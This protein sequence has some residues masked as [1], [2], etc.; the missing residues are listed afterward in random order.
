[1]KDRSPLPIAV[2]RPSRGRVLHLAPH[3]DDDVIACG[4]TL[5]HHA[6]AGDPVRVVVV[7]SG[8]AGDPEGRYDSASYAELRQSEA[9][10]GGEHLGLH[11]YEF[12]NFPEGHEPSAEELVGATHKLA[13][14]I[15]EFAPDI[16]YSPWI[17]EHHLD[18]YVLARV[19]RMAVFALDFQGQAWGWEVWTPLIPTHIVDITEVYA[20]KVAAL[21]EHKSQ[22]KYQDLVHMG[23]SISA[24][25]SMYISLEAEHGEALA[26]LGCP[27]ADDEALLGQAGI[28]RGSLRSS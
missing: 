13:A 23:L 26:P 4:G 16:V 7:F 12:W 24:Q 20:K 28:T 11:D 1:M 21:R 15:E 8:E 22:L 14:C 9:R 3:A 10:A 6:A 17:G 27:S 25:R 2:L 5:S 19:A 18:H